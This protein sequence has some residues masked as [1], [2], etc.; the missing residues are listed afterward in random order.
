MREY[1]TVV[2]L[3]RRAI[4]IIEEERQCLF[5]GHQVNGKL[6]I[7]DEIDR[8]VADAIASMDAWLEEARLIVGDASTH[9]EVKAN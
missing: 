5:E 7:T 4:P 2:D 9:T 6:V 3:I 1:E 8:N